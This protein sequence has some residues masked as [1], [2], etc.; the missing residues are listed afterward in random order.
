MNDVIA[1]PPVL[2]E[3][4]TFTATA[5]V[6]GLTRLALEPSACPADKVARPPV[7][8]AVCVIDALASS[9]IE[10]IHTTITQA[11]LA[12][13]QPRH[14]AVT[15]EGRKVAANA[16]AILGAFTTVNT[17]RRHEV[18]H[19]EL[20]V[21]QKTPWH[22]GGYRHQ[23]V[24]VGG[25]VAPAPERLAELMDDLAEFTDRRP[26]DVLHAAVAH[27]QFETIHPYPDGNGRIGRALLAGHLRLPVSVHIA[28]HRQDY[29][30][31]L[32]DYR[33][34]DAGPIVRIVAAAAAHGATLHELASG[35]PAPEGLSSPAQK[36]AARAARH[37]VGT[38]ARIAP[39][40][41]DEMKHG[42]AEL[43]REG[44]LHPVSDDLGENTVYA[45]LPVVSH[46]VTASDL[47]IY[48]SKSASTYERKLRVHV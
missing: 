39:R 33:L 27:A 19:R 28:Q 46:W 6:R 15:A 47:D 30:D 3:R 22:A 17:Y 34:G 44:H 32:R 31:A 20:M 21:A 10:G 8:E 41:T 38:L 43:I 14:P 13:K 40:P 23:L 26:A 11:Y 12:F 35:G 29:Y 42:L 18:G 2:V 1:V 37:P 5:A 4:V 24:K 9:D 7:T 16:H 36:A 25:H 45:Y 48:G